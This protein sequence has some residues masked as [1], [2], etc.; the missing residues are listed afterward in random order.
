VLVFF[1]YVFGFIAQYVMV[2]LNPSPEKK[3]L[4]KIRSFVK[5]EGRISA[6]HQAALEESWFNYGLSVADGQLNLTEVFG[7]DA[8]CI[9]E[10][11][12]GNGQCLL[13]LAQR[14]PE[15]NFIGVEVHT[16]GVGALLYHANQENITNIRVYS[17]DAIAVLSEC[18]P[19]QSLSALLLFF[20]DPWPK[21]RHHKRRLVQSSFAE[22]V[23]RKF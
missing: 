13:T 23:A 5:R 2:T 1:Y 6:T 14:Y 21:Q 11:G 18:I 12:F 22:L 7:R 4:R 15:Y 20:P 8:P 17:E 10:I 9:L 3:Y 16:P 19:Q